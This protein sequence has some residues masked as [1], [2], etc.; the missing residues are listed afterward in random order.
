MIYFDS[1]TKRDLVNKFYN[2]TAE[3]GYL[4]I[5]HSETLDRDETKYK[6]VMPSVIQEGVTGMIRQKK[7]RVLVV[8]DSLFFREILS[9]GYPPI[10]KLKLWPRLSI[11]LTHAIRSSNM[12][13]TL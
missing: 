5:G 6:Y 4:F 12:S 10:L 11:R 2:L 7:I 13:P 8:D 1:D 9:K 3:G